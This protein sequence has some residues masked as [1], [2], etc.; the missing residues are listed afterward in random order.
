MRTGITTGTRDP[1][2]RRIRR[3][4]S[5]LCAARPEFR[6]IEERFGPAEIRL[7]QPGMAALARIIV[8]QQLSTYA[9]TSIFAR[10]EA[11]GGPDSGFFATASDEALR[12]CGLSGPKIRA[13][14][15][16]A[17][18]ALDF[19]GLAA[20]SDEA[21]VTALTAVKGIGRWTAEIYLLAALGRTDIWPAGDVGLQAAVH[22]FAGLSER[23]GVAEMERLAEPWRPWRSAAARLLWHYLD[24]SKMPV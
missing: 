17:A 6:A 11:A 23:P 19:D 21:A 5:A 15:A 7:R 2:T 9:A 1:R 8:G 16:L 18:A 12:G 24:R 22:R 20:M 14:R 13:C 4:I 3:A 10:I